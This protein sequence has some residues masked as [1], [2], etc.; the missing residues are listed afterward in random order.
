M[1][2]E[3]VTMIKVNKELDSSPHEISPM[4]T[5]ETFTDLV[6]NV[7]VKFPTEVTMEV[8]GETGEV[9]MEFTPYK[10]TPRF[11]WTISSN[12]DMKREEVFYFGPDFIVLL[13][14]LIFILS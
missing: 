9:A 6:K 11:N 13:Y 2:H 10:S 8:P 14:C 3:L 12:R 4:S 5:R 1:F 7:L